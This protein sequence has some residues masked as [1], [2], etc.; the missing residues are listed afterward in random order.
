MAENYKDAMDRSKQ[1]LRTSEEHHV[2]WVS[3]KEI[4]TLINISDTEIMQKVKEFELDITFSVTSPNSNINEQAAEDFINF[5]LKDKLSKFL[6][7]KY[8]NHPKTI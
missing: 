7:N 5:I 6:S 4:A 8:F 2:K 3:I 1:K